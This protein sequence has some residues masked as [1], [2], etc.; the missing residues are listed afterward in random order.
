M[1][2]YKLIFCIMALTALLL[3]V[4]CSDRGSGLPNATDY[5]NE[6][7]LYPSGDHSFD[8]HLALQLGNI[9]EMWLGATY[10]PKEA[11]GPPH[12][13]YKPV[14]TLILL[15][16][17]DGDKL[18]YFRAGLLELVND[19]ISA[20]EI[21]PMVIHCPSNTSAFGGMFYGNSLLAGEVDSILSLDIL[22]EYFPTAIPATIQQKSALGIGGVGMGAYGALRA[23]LTNTGVDG[24]RFSSVSV[25]D[26][27]LDFDGTSGSGG[28]I[29]FFGVALSEQQ[30]LLRYNTLE[31]IS[32]DTSASGIDTV[33]GEPVDTFTFRK[34]DTGDAF[35]TLPV[36][37]LFIGGSVAFSP[38]DTV[39][40]NLNWDNS[41]QLTDPDRATLNNRGAAGTIIT[42]ST[43]MID[44]L[45]GRGSQPWCYHLPFDSTGA[46]SSTI[47]PLWMSNNIDSLYVA[48]GGNALDNTK[49]WIGNNPASKWNYGTMTSSFT[50]FIQSE[51]PASSVTVHQYN[52]I[53]QTGSTD[54]SV[55]DI[56]REML[57]FHSDN[58]YAQ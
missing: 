19:M 38:H 27:P 20:G 10:I 28:L 17:Q 22:D 44:G 55:Y 41:L 47:W 18:Y 33:F 37:R 50:S 21:G 23:A 8:I 7:G 52:G 51:L 57:K 24:S 16:P 29:D 48:A 53:G 3:G 36:S 43:T 14:P 1:S 32:V 58:F 39:M 46:V 40:G 42:D 30:A 56:L 45:I 26:G 34:F 12:G 35:V 15:A 11:F 54:E 31:I 9:N 4:G 6:S 13:T 5:D 2:K 25:A 49:I